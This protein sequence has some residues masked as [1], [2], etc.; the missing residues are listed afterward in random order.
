MNNLKT[1]GDRLKTSIIVGLYINYHKIRNI[2]ENE[3]N[4]FDKD[5]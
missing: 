3:N 2:E 4:F 1:Q 5:C